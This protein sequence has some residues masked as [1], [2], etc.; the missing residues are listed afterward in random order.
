M[1]RGAFTTEG[2]EG[3]KIFWRVARGGFNTKT[4]RDEGLG[5]GVGHGRTRKARKGEGEI[6]ARRIQHEDAKE[7]R[8]LRVLII[9]Y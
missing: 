4:R 9:D 6:G 8:L 7:R 1:A 3:T 5:R 2:T